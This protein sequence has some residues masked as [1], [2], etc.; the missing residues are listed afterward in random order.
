MR[1]EERQE[2]VALPVRANPPGAG[3]PFRIKG[4]VAGTVAL[5]AIAIALSWNGPL[6][7]SL[8]F[9]AGAC[10]VGELLWV[11]MPLGRVTVSMAS[12]VQFAAVLVLPR[13][14]A[15]VAAAASVLVA[16]LLFMRK[17]AIRAT[18]NAGHG[19]LTV[20]ATSWAMMACETLLRGGPH[21][22]SPALATLL[23]G[24]VIYFIVNT[25]AVSFAVAWNE[26]VS[27]ARA[28]LT[29]FGNRYELLSNGA[30][31]SLGALLASLYSVHGMFG[32][33]LVLLPL[34]VAYEGYRVHADG[35]MAGRPATEERQAA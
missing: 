25:G 28:W 17:P 26:G 33:M 20:G 1:G 10:L 15:M 5:A 31:F 12:A 11:R 14:H 13:G 16:E 3:L 4:L 21:A 19:A 8:L 23:V 29:N 9:W 22:E 24:A 7:S 27:F 18:Y 30:L 6:T 2:P 32:T 35:Q 34:L